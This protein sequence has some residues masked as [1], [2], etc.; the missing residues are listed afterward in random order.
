MNRDKATMKSI[1]ENARALRTASL[2]A[3]KKPDNETSSPR[4]LQN[5]KESQH[6]VSYTSLP[7]IQSQAIPHHISRNN[8]GMSYQFSQPDINQSRQHMESMYRN[9]YDN[10]SMQLSNMSQIND[11]IYFP[12]TEYF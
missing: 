6:Q 9:Y 8:N 3:R 2:N 1:L 7:N 4:P 10:E 5:L 11:S 12:K